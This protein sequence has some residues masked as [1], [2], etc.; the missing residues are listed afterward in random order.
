MSD[1]K[2]SRQISLRADEDQINRLDKLA[3]HIQNTD[4]RGRRPDYSEIL[5]S[6]IGWGNSK[7]LTNSERKY[8]AGNTDEIGKE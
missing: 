1:K 8:L 2:K 5:R 7:L 4:K 3:D 6:V